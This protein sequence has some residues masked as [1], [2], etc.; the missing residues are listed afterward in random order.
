MRQFWGRILHAKAT[1][2]FDGAP[3]PCT[4]LRETFASALPMR[5]WSSAAARTRVLIGLFDLDRWQPWLADAYAMLDASERCRVKS[6]RAVADR[7]P[8]ALSYA[9]H[10]LLLGRILD[11]DAADVPIGRDASG[12]PR[13]PGTGLFTSL[14]HAGRNVAALAVTAT[15][16]VGV[17]IESI[18][19]ASFMPEIAHRICHPAD[20]AEIAGQYG[21]QRN[22]DLLA[23]WVRKEAFLKAAGIGLKCEMQTFPAPDKALVALPGRAMSRISMLDVGRHWVAAIASAPETSVTCAWLPASHRGSASR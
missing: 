4:T 19:R 5:G 11:C 15:G 2:D 7:D 17:D 3:L 12:C 10:R 9:L 14:S 23:L 18:S 16:P 1:H 22:H 6:R 8:L 13:L 20:A 21:P